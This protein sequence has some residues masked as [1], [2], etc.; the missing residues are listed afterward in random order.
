MEIYAEREGNAEVAHFSFDAKRG[1][2][3][4]IESIDGDIFVLIDGI[5]PLAVC[6]ELPLTITLY[7]LPDQ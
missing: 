3:I 7:E 1:I 5:K 6:D 4:S 2:K